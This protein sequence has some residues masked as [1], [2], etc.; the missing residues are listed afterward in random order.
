MINEIRELI[1][2][3]IENND[4]GPSKMNSGYLEILFT[5]Y[6]QDDK[7]LIRVGGYDISDWNRHQEFGPF[8][9]LD[10][11]LNYVKEKLKEAL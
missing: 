10:E 11:G 8:D 5:P 1:K 6:H 2:K 9:T 7:V 4:E 3:I